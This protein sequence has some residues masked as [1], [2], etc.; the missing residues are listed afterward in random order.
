MAAS[1]TVFLILG[2]TVA[3]F[4]GDRM[5]PDVVSL[6]ALLALAP[7]GVLTTAEAL[8]GFADPIVVMIAAPSGSAAVCFRPA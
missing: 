4:V 2:V 7:T 1:T 5:R 6:L 3:L 8:A